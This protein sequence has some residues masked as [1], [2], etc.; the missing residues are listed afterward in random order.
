MPVN[1]WPR[2]I[3]NFR[4]PLPIGGDIYTFHLESGIFFDELLVEIRARDKFLVYAFLPV[5][6]VAN[7]IFGPH[8]V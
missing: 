7:I 1:S 6:D 3:R 5:S 2:L 8:N 4:T